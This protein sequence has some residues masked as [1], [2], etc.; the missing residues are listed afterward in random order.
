MENTIKTKVAMYLRCSTE[1]QLK[2]YGLPVQEERLR[3]YA[4]SQGFEIN[5]QYVYRDEG[6]SGSLP[7]ELRP[8]LKNL[9]A[10]A[11]QNRFDLVLVLK[12]DRFFRNSRLLLNALHQLDSYKVSFSSVTEPFDTSHP[13][14]EGRSTYASK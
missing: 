8:G 3:A 6:F 10:D 12:V 11:E 14:E 13:Y 5:N 2:G 7:I 4:T 1:E 9:F